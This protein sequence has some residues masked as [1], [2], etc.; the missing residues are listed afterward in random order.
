MERPSKG[1]LWP[2]LLV[3][4]FSA[5]LGGVISN[6]LRHLIP[7][8]IIHDLF[9]QG[10]KVGMVPPL[11]LDLGIFHITF[12]FTLDLSLVAILCVVVGLLLYRKAV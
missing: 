8:G 12:G 7:G 5:I 11:A 3:V 9:V 6:I 1:P 2:L 10:I 4:L